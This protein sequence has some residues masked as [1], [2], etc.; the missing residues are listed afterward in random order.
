MEVEKMVEL[1]RDRAMVGRM[2]VRDKQLMLEAAD[3]L[4]M[5]DERCTE[6]AGILPAC[7]GCEGKTV[8]GERTDKCVYN[9]DDG[10][11]MDRARKNYFA[12]KTRVEESE[13]ETEGAREILEE[14]KNILLPIVYLD[15]DG[16]WHM[17]RPYANKLH[18][19]VEAFLDLYE[20]HMGGVDQK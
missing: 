12:M 16:K 18:L 19:F 11:C 14:I 20:K 9:I 7:E 10:Y 17:V 4:E 15:A 8:L 1:L 5:L 6:F 2:E 13:K 3:R